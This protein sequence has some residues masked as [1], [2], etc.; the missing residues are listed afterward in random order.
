VFNVVQD[1]HTLG[2]YS[3]HAVVDHDL[4]SLVAGLRPRAR[5]SVRARR[6]EERSRGQ[7]SLAK[8]VPTCT[9][10]IGRLASLAQT[11]LY[12]STTREANADNFYARGEMIFTSFLRAYYHVKS[13][14]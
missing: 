1:V 5:R 12:F 7:P 14:D 8:I 13:A 3:M 10:R 11:L 6:A 9:R 4:G 2:Y